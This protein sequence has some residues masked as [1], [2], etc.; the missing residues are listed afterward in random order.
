MAKSL[1]DVEKLDTET[2]KFTV[3]PLSA[4]GVFKKIVVALLVIAEFAAF[5]AINP[6][7]G[8]VATAL[9]LLFLFWMM[10]G[11]SWNRGRRFTQFTVGPT[12]ITMLENGATATTFPI[13]EIERMYITAPK[14]GELTVHTA[15]GAGGTYTGVS[16]SG[17]VNAGLAARSWQ[18]VVQVRGVEH[19]LAGGLTQSMASSLSMQVQKAL[20]V[21][22]R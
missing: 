10:K 15:I 11:A 18:V 12:G 6:R 8:F 4:L 22:W 21:S 3:R 19:W 20:P 5:A 9:L 1:Y 14:A 13:A 7:L 16:S 2:V 17:G